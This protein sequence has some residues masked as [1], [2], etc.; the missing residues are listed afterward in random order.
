MD[1]ANL[2]QNQLIG[3]VAKATAIAEGTNKVSELPG[4]LVWASPNL[5]EVLLGENDEVISLAN[6]AIGG[7]NLVVYPNRPAP[8]FENDYIITDKD[9]DGTLY[10]DIGEISGGKV[11]GTVFIVCNRVETGS[12]DKYFSLDNENSA[13]PNISVLGTT[14]SG[15]GKE[16][17]IGLKGS[18]GDVF[19]SSGNGDAPANNEN[20]VI[21]I[22]FGDGKLDAY[23]NYQ[24]VIKGADIAAIG[25]IDGINRFVPFGASINEGSSFLVPSGDFGEVIVTSGKLSD[26]D[27][28]DVISYLDTKWTIC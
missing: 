1:I 23:V 5:D 14:G 7:N 21:A 6:R 2:I 25:N 8:V 18:D 15:S 16:I 28:I 10:A 4:L 17:M 13:A 27:M 24:K 9:V 11:E 22:T 19:V 26:K 20:A 12:T 3:D